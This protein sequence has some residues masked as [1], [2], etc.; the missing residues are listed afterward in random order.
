MVVVQGRAPGISVFRNPNLDE[1]A[2]QAQETSSPYRHRL[3]STIIMDHCL[4]ISEL[5]RSICDNLDKATSLSVA[6]TC[7]AFLEPGLDKVWRNIATLE[8][9][10]C[11]LP[12][13]IWKDDRELLLVSLRY[14]SQG[15]SLNPFNP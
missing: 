13:E 6:L 9:L 1:T 12:A 4:R 5:I 15:R 10:A 14:I 8:P 3:P 7:K 2:V 11:C